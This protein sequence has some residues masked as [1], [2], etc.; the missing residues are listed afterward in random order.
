MV[1]ACNKHGRDEKYIQILV[2]NSEGKRP[3]GIL[4]WEDGVIMGLREITCESVDWM[5]LA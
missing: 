3:L 1:G 2:G 5:H 4:R